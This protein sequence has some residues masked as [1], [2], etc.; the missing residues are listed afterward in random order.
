MKQAPRAWY[1]KLDASLIALGFKRSPLEHAVYRRGDAKS[2]LLIGVYV[3][4]LIITGT[5]I[6]DI[7]LFK[8]EMQR[9]FKMS[10]LGLLS[11]Y[12]GIKVEQRNGEIKLSQCSY[13]KKILEMAKMIGCNPSA[14]PME[15]RLKIKKKDGSEAVVASLYR[16]VIGSLRY[17]VNTR[18]DIAFAVGIASRYMEV[19]S[20][21]HWIIVKQILRYIQ[22]TLGYGCCYKRDEKG[23]VLTGYTDS[24]LAGDLDDRKS[25]SGVLSMLGK[26]TVT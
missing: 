4:D 1:A 10:D 19:P 13:A 24:D 9:L 14:T 12:L 20:K 11:Y 17:L 7:K 15:T 21:N 5:S 6:G 8:A 2:F 23:A 3:D 22:G 18:P 16:S 25:T 26:N